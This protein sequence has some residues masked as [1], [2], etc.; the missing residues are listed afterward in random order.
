MAYENYALPAEMLLPL[1]MELIGR[2]EFPTDAECALL[3]D[4][5]ALKVHRARETLIRAQKKA[6][7]RPEPAQVKAL[8]AKTLWL[9]DA[10]TVNGAGMP[11]LVFFGINRLICAR[12]RHLIRNKLGI[13]ALIGTH[14][15]GN[16]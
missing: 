2:D 5:K 14:R 12:Q 11:L 7:T 6:G 13:P 16:S 1:Y 8:V 9:T 15:D 4:S 3:G 10:L